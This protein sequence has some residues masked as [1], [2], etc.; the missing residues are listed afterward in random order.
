MKPQLMHAAC[1]RR[2]LRRC[3]RSWA[4]E[5]QTC[6]TT[7]QPFTHGEKLRL[8]RHKAQQFLIGPSQSR[9]N[10]LLHLHRQCRKAGLIQEHFKKQGRAP[11]ALL[12]CRHAN[13]Q[14]HWR[15]CVAT[16][17]PKPITLVFGPMRLYLGGPAP[18]TPSS[19][20]LPT[21]PDTLK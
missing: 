5:I 18:A 10:S 8:R 1:V 20:H 2:E 7:A 13:D 9:G 3:Q 15:R 14:F 21:L 17:T 4:G 19:R 16:S 12:A 11:L 6:G